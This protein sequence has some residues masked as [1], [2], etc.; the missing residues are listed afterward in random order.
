LTE[1]DLDGNKIAD[2]TPL[3]R[4]TSLTELCLYKNFG[5]QGNPKISDLSPLSNLT[6]LKKLD[7]GRLNRVRNLSPLSA[8]TNLREFYLYSKNLKD[9]EPLLNI[10]LKNN[11]VIK[12]S[13]YCE[14]TCIEILQLWG[15]SS[16]VC[17]F[18]SNA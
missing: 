3:A 7:L 12:I 15:R 13:K 18:Y 10:K 4:L 17:L 5:A 8:L 11:A 2:I 6:K 9:L 16:N 1:L 14:G